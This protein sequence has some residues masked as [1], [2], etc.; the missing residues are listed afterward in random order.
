MTQALIWNEG[1]ADYFEAR[2]DGTEKSTLEEV[3]TCPYMDDKAREEL[4]EI[5]A[6]AEVLVLESDIRRLA[7]LKRLALESGHD[8]FEGFAEDEIRDCTFMDGMSREELECLL[9]RAEGTIQEATNQRVS[10]LKRL[11]LVI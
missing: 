11:A 8:G 10:G 6:E 1:S 2:N 3:R 5:H 4:E 9:D 7:A